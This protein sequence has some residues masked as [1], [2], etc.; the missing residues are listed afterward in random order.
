M[1]KIYALLFSVLLSS[2]AFAQ[3]GACSP[4]GNLLIIT[5][6]DGGILNINVDA[7]IPNLKIGVCSYESIQINITGAFAG[8]V[9]GVAYAGYNANN[10][11]CATG[12]TN[13]S[14]V[15]AGSA[16]TNITLLPAATLANPNGYGLIVCG[17]S[18]STTTNQGG[19]NTVDQI[20]NYFLNFFPGSVLYAHKVQYACWATTQIVSSGGCCGTTTDIV[21]SG[22]NTF[23]LYPNPAINSINL[24]FQTMLNNATIKIFNV[25]GKLIKEEINLNGT[26]VT[27][28]I[29]DFS[30]GIYFIETTNLGNISHVKLIKE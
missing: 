9:T 13:T 20:E 1:K 10:D 2:A 22:K 15:G 5:N 23:T 11:N 19:C 4:T 7:N 16:T 26:D 27:I 14:I 24:T 29:S 8:N 6:Y 18:C 3:A 28:D 17:Y 12:V 25:S 21:D 30:K